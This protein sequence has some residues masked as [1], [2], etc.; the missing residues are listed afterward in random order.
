M[1]HALI[2]LAL[3]LLV[4]ALALFWCNPQAEKDVQAHYADHKQYLDSQVGD[5]ALQLIC[6]EMPDVWMAY[7]QRSRDNRQEQLINESI[8]ASRAAAAASAAN[9]AATRNVSRQLDNI[10]QY[11]VRVNH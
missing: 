3:L 6:N 8:R 2:T 10:R 7:M 9:A 11:G 5:A 1:I 4:G